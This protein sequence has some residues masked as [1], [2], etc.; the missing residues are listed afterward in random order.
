MGRCLVSGLR[1]RGGSI[2]VLSHPCCVWF[3]QRLA[4]HSPVLLPTHQLPQRPCLSLLLQTQAFTFC[5]H[6]FT[7]MNLDNATQ[8]DANLQLSLNIALVQPVSRGLV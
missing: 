5:H 4:H 7:H 6:T 1:A 2:A 3:V 8:S